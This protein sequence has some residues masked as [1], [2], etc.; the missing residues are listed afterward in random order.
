MSVAGLL[1]VLFVALKLLGVI[2][3]SWWLVTLPAWAGLALGAV[4]MALGMGVTGVA[5]LLNR[6]T[7]TLYRKT[8]RMR[9]R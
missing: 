6:E 2:D 8:A 3:W 9:R 7:T 1:L 5:R 4:I